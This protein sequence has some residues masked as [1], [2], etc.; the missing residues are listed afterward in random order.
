[1]LADD[2]GNQGEPVKAKVARLERYEGIGFLFHG[3]SN[4]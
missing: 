4:G 2:L 3:I 1:V